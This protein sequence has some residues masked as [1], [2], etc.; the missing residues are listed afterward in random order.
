MTQ[1]NSTSNESCFAIL[2]L[3]SHPIKRRI[4]GVD[5]PMILL[6]TTKEAFRHG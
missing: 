4:T 2:V 5:A 6:T 1:L 3:L